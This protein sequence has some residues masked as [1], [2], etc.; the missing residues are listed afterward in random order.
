ME[1]RRDSGRPRDI[2]VKFSSY[3]TRR[4]VYG[5]RTKTKD[6]GYR[7]VYINEDLTKLRNM[8]LMKARHMVKTKHIHSAWSSDGTTLVRDLADNKHRTIS[9]NDLAVRTSS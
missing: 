1:K 4:K 8:L 9:E 5:A 2:I 7:G 3:R 6:N